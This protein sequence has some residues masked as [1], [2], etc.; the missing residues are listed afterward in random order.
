M[1]PPPTPSGDSVRPGD[2]LGGKYRVTRVLGRGEP[3]PA[4]EEGSAIKR[5]EALE[6]NT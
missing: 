2:V 5:S 4:D 6:S 1:S 3:P